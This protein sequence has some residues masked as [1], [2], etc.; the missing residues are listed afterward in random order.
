MSAVA[1]KPVP[2]RRRGLRWIVVLVVIVVLVAG[3]AFWLNTSASAATNAV[4]TLNVFLPVTS[5]AH[6]GGAYAAATTGAT[7]QP[8]DGVKTDAKGRAAI[9]LPD[10]TLT[11]LASN[12][13]ITLTSA[14]FAK[15]GNLQDASLAQR[16]G[17]TFTNVQHLVSGATFKVSGQSA[18]ATVRGTKFE[19]YI[20][21]DGTMVVK[22]FV[23]ELDFDGK[24]HV[25]L[26]AP[27]QATAD[28]QG[29]VGPAGPIVPEP[30]DPFGPELAASD[31]TSQGT[32]PGTEQDFIGAP[33]HNGEQQQYAYS[34]AGG[35]LVKA[36]LGYPGSAMK[37]DVKAPDGQIYSK[38]GASPIVVTINKGPAGIYTILVTGVS[39]L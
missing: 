4:A 21:A 2:R 19:V 29:N 33:L 3:A 16:A 10:G 18:T 5:V 11:R 30:G 25:H 28:P 20:K 23:G 32:T 17:R 22:L 6:N 34:F 38:F 13:E 15:D 1:A 24:N 26:T 8:G 7:V 14:H 27:Q 12:T 36:A 35:G 39:G 31:A 37:L 9:Q